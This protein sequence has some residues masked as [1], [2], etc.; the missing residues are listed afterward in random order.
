MRHLAG[1][2]VDS[3]VAG[4]GL[5]IHEYAQID[6]CH[7]DSLVL[8]YSVMFKFNASTFQTRVCEKNARISQVQTIKEH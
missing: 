5:G 8:A 3:V 7:S 2:S 6:S 4:Q 1:D